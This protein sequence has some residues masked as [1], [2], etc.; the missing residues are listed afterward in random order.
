M[1]DTYG[2]RR[3][4]HRTLVGILRKISQLEHL[5][6]DGRIILKRVF[7]NRMRGCGQ[8]W[9]GLVQ[10]QMVDSCDHGNEP[11]GYKKV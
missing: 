6:V 7:K 10:G 4:A 1:C 2:R 9:C 8:E 3:D 5:F 11:L